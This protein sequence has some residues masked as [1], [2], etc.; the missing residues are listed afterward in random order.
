LAKF[1][2]QTSCNNTEQSCQKSYQCKEFDAN[3]L[4]GLFTVENY[5]G[6][7]SRFFWR[8][9]RWPDFFLAAF[10]L[11]LKIFSLAAEFGGFGSTMHHDLMRR[12]H[13]RITTS[14]EVIVQLVL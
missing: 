13:A 1:I 5:S 2:V 9:F 10:R 14:S 8:F 7:N 4:Y 11:M 12:A 6:Y 3:D